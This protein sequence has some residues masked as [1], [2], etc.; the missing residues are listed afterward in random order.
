MKPGRRDRLPLK[1][2]FPGPR[3]GSRYIHLSLPDRVDEL[4]MA[5]KKTNSTVRVGALCAVLEV[6]LD[7][8]AHV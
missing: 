6:S 8:T 5:G 3:N 1:N 7:W 2:P 4:Y